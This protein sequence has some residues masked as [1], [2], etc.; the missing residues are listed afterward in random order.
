MR[1]TIQYPIL[2]TL[3]CVMAGSHGAQ[4][5]E[6]VRAAQVSLFSDVKA[7]RIGDVL[8]VLISESNSASKNAQTSTRKQN[9]SEAKGEATTGALSGLFPGI[10]GSMDVSNRSNGQGSTTRS[11]SFSSQM[12]VRVVDVLPTGDLVIEGTKTMEINEDTEVITLSGVVR[13]EDIGAGNSVYSYQI[14]NAKFTYKGKGSVSQ[15]HRP[16]LLVRLFNWIL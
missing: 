7:A 2:I 12:S 10:G 16:G 11:G 1:Q 9:T 6:Q 3:L 14:A 13:P 4:A 8:T 15:A 5:Q